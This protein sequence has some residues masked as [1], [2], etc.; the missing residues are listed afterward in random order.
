VKF[1]NEQIGGEEMKRYTARSLSRRAMRERCDKEAVVT[2]RC[3]T[4]V[5]GGETHGEE[6]EQATVVGGGEAMACN[7]LGKSKD[8]GKNTQGAEEYCCH[9]LDVILISCE[10]LLMM[11]LSATIHN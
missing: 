5:E 6:L 10:L 9:L 1:F 7:W 2:E 4:I 11:I 8:L 3:M